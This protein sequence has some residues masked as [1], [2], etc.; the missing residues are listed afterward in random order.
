MDTKIRCGLLAKPIAKEQ[1]GCMRY[2]DKIFMALNA[3]WR[4]RPDSRPFLARLIHTRCIRRKPRILQT[5]T[6]FF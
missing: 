6:D 3:V 1:Q 5:Q 4:E 2:P